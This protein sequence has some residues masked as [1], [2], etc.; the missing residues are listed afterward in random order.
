MSQFIDALFSYFLF[1]LVHILVAV[2]AVLVVLALKQHTLISD[3][4]DSMQVVRVRHHTVRTV[5]AMKKV[6]N[7]SV[8]FVFGLKKK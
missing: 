2:T 7:V 5:V 6:Q 3:L 1:V 8:S 4:C